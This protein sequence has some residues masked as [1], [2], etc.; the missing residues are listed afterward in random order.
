MFTSIK[1][2]IIGISIS[3][4][5]IGAFLFLNSWHYKPIKELQ[6]TNQTLQSN[7]ETLSSLYNI[8]EVNLSKQAIQGYIDGVGR[9]DNFDGKNDTIDFS[10][11]IY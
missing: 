10:N 5:A 8:C 11:I 2:Y 7:L 1:A 3:A 9:E 6:S 4:I